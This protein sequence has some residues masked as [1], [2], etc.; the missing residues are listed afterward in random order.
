VAVD[1]RVVAV[2]D[3]RTSGAAVDIRTAVEAVESRAAA[4]LRD[5]LAAGGMEMAEIRVEEE[6]TVGRPSAPLPEAASAPRSA[7]QPRI[8]SR[9]GCRARSWSRS[10]D[11]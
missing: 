11:T 3:I 8:D 4:A 2:V 9:T 7:D 6:G 5:S 10:W 1:N